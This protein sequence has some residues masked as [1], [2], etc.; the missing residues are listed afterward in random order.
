MPNL[1]GNDFARATIER[2]IEQGSVPNTMLF[3]GP[4]GVGK[5]LFALA[6]AERLMG[7][8]HAAKIGTSNHPDIHIYRPEGKS[9]IHTMENMRALIQE[10]SLPPFE[11]PVKF[12][13]LHDAHQ[14]QPYSSNA[15]LK[16][17]EEPPQDTYI[18]LLTS[19]IDAMLPTILSRCRKIPFFP[20]PQPQIEA[21]VKANWNQKEEEARRIAFLSHGSL[22]RA[23]KIA[24]QAELP[25]RSLLLEILTLEF[26]KDYP[27]LGKLSTALEAALIDEDAEE[28]EESSMHQQTDLLF[29]EITAWYR[30]LHLVKEGVALEYLYHLDHIDRLRQIASK[31][32]PPLE[33]VLDK[34]AHC[35]LALQRSIKLRNV[36]EYFFL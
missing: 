31:P 9:A 35:R 19:S 14:M 32:L 5:S 28:E 34:I 4:D 25:F 7:K 8:G 2:M 30:D 17:L 29:E 21:F 33:L 20:I 6:L 27:Q 13:I 12:F 23:Q 15:L 36:L 3:Y 26:P 18:I 24:S 16:T 11:A 10:V 1:I 22:S